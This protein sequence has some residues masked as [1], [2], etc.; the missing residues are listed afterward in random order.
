MMT[1]T[2]KPGK[3]TSCWKMRNDD[4]DREV[5]AEWEPKRC[6]PAYGENSWIQAAPSRNVHEKRCG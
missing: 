6:R 4:D 3:G 5:M 2:E 1:A